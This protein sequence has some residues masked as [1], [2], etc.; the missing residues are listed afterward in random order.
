MSTWDSTSKNEIG[1][2]FAYDERYSFLKGIP[3]LIRTAELSD[4]P[5]LLAIYNDEV[6]NGVA[7]F[8]TEPQTMEERRAWFDAHNVENHPLSSRWVERAQDKGATWIVV[9]PRFTRSAK[10]ADLYSPIRPGT[11]IADD[12]ERYGHFDT[13]QFGELELRM[14]ILIKAGLASKWELE[15]CYSLD[16]ALKLYALYIRDLD[17][18]RIQAEEMRRG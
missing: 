7:T 17:I 15:T 13:T 16:E 2:V 9:D 11:D 12:P 10:N 8:D 5:A 14:Y 6:K 3:M 4:L 1:T 18:Q